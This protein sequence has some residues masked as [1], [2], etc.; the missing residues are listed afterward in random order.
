MGT[1]WITGAG[2]FIGRH[3]AR[4]VSRAGH[5]VYGI[6]HGNWPNLES[7]AWGLSGWLNGDIDASNLDALRVMGG[8][9][10][11]VIHLAGGSS[12]GLSLDNPLEDFSRSVASTARLLE[13]MRTNQSTAR[14]TSASSAAVYGSQQRGQIPPTARTQPF[15]PYGH[16][17]LMMEQLCRSYSEAFG[18]RCSIV[19]LFSVYGPWLRK[20]LL[21]DICSQ[22]ENGAELIELGG[23]GDELR[24]WIE[25]RDVVKVMEAASAIDGDSVIVLNGGTGLATPVKIVADAVIREWGSHALVTFS[26]ESRRG[27]PFSLIST[28]PLFADRS[29]SCEIGLDDGIATYVKWFKKLRAA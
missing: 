20:Q 13:W 4:H 24:D 23:T 29:V 27:D 22:L 19:R 14:L 1:F 16:H 8:D 5:A 10:S 3:T 6:G 7:S 2:G 18:I 9:P 15:S 28:P 21:W 25:I 11:H 17:K 12:V 26:G